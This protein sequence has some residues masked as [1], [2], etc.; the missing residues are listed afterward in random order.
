MKVAI[1]HYW[2][3]NWRGGEKVVEAL[4][5][6]YPQADLF[7]HVYDE[8]LTEGKLKGRNITTTFISKLPGAKKHYQKY[9][10]LMPI[11][12]E[13]LDLREYDL[14]ISSESGPAKGIIISPDATHICYCHSPMR[15]VWDMY[16]DYLKATGR[17][18]R[19]FMRPL[20]HY[21]KMWDRL[22]AESS[23]CEEKED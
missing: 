2:F 23:I 3:I 19:W 20:I 13:Q 11:A 17:V 12:L 4:L 18:T 6:L 21:L 1:V 5:D 14:V 9:L 16:P 15:Y 10:P 7:T 22:S 8:S